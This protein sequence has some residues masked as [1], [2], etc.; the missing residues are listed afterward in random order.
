MPLEEIPVFPDYPPT[1]PNVIARAVKDHGGR[2]FLVEGDRRF[3]FRD[4]ERESARLARGLLSLGVGK[5][6]RVAIMLPN[7]P[8]WALAW[9]AAARIGAF[10]LPLSTLFQPREIAWAL[11]EADVDTLLIAATQ[12]G[13]DYLERLERALPGLA[14]QPSSRLF[15]RE[16][17]YL[18]RIVVWGLSGTSGDRRWALRG[19]QALYEAAERAPVIDD[20]FLAQVE[21]SVTPADWLI[22]ICTS[23]STSKPKI[24]VHTHGSMLRITH[25]FRRYSFHMSPEDRTYSGMPLFWLGGLNGSLM[26]AT[27]AGACVLFSP[28]PAPADV[29]DLLLRER[30][31]RVSVWPPQFKPLSDLARERGLNIT[32]LLLSARPLDP[33]GKPI[34]QSR[35]ITS[36][37]GMTE[38]FGPHGAG[39]WE[40]VLPE[41]HGASWGRNFQG[42]ARKIVDAESGEALPSGQEGE[43]YIRGF[44]MMD[45]YYKRE[46]AEVF[47]PD[48]WFATGDT[49]SIDAEGYL[50]FKGRSS[51][52]IKTGGANVSPQEVEAVLAGYPGVAEAMVLGLPDE[53]RGEAVVAV[54]VAR[55]GAQLDGAA[56]QKRMREEVSA[57]KVP[58]RMLIMDYADIPRTSAGKVQKNALKELL[59]R[60]KSDRDGATKP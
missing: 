49:C 14:A 38:C 16:A 58:R 10:T 59:V 50:Y 44:S 42:L 37:L 32:P 7:S 6:T 27:Y 2:E 36:L 29:L 15:L 39:R 3:T 22:G 45:G 11:A 24:V 56:L 5:A 33:E 17:P 54:L 48:G 1:L 35:R 23:G 46:R 18:R 51:E 41:Q 26:P 19:P 9:W 53:E 12:L 25:T 34:P 4:A 60:G 55:E 21:K 47:K 28:S 43:L 8:D 13:H 30:A 52:M 31:T 40:E 20:D 57:Y